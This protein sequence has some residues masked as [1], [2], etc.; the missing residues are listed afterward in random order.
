MAMTKLEE[1]LWDNDMYCDTCAHY[2]KNTPKANT[3]N[4]VCGLADNKQTNVYDGQ[5]LRLPPEGMCYRWK[6]FF[7]S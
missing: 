2:T 7:N 4:D 6:E 1:F 5:H 3:V